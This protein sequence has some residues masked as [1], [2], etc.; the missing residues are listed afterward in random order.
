MFWINLLLGWTVIGWVV[1]LV[2]AIDKSNTPKVYDDENEEEELIGS[3]VL[4]DLNGEKCKVLKT[5]LEKI[6]KLKDLFTKG[7]ISEEEFL[8]KS[9]P[10]SQ[11]YVKQETVS[12]EIELQALTFSYERGEISKEEYESKKSELLEKIVE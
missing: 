8:E 1:A 9:R 3:Y 12:P 5:D 4:I 2:M 10:I 6:K 7:L 11:K